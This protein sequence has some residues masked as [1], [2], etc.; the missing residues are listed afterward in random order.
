MRKSAFL[1]LVEICIQQASWI[2]R[3]KEGSGLAGS[4]YATRSQLQKQQPAHADRAGKF[5]AGMTR[6]DGNKLLVATSALPPLTSLHKIP[7]DKPHP[8]LIIIIIIISVHYITFYSP[9]TRSPKAP[10]RPGERDDQAR[11]SC[12]TS[13]AGT[14]KSRRAWMD[15]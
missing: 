12:G 14:G 2:Q 5:M 7:P 13:S 1:P 15:P 6:S 3:A 8:R 9:L 10:L 11:T 4:S